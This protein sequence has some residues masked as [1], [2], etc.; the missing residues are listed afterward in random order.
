VL[1]FGHA[2]LT[3][4]A[5]DGAGTVVLLAFGALGVAAIPAAYAARARRA[6]RS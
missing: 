3:S 5:L 6:A 2:L 1:G 4:G